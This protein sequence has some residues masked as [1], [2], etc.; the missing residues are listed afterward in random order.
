VDYHYCLVL[1]QV[2]AR[3]GT[4]T[5]MSSGEGTVLIKDAL[6]IEICGPEEDYL[7]VID[8]PGIFCNPT[9]EVTTK[10]NIRLV[11]NI[12]KKYT[13]HS[14]TIVLTVLPSNVDIATQEILY[15]C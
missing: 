6:K 7:T 11:Q 2:N 14:H 8:L 12:V 5:D 1:G 13:K 4:R 10:A 15:A 9:E 3:M